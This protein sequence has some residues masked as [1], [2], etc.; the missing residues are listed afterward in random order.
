MSR[1]LDINGQVY[2]RLTV[3]SFFG[4]EAAGGGQKASVWECLCECGNVVRKRGN[5][6]RT[7]NTKSCGCLQRECRDALGRT[8][9]T[10]GKS[11]TKEYQSYNHARDRCNN[12][13]SEY[14]K[15]YGGRGIKFLFTS[16]EIFLAEVGLAPTFSHSIDRFPN[17]NGHYEPDNVRWATKKEQSENRR[18]TRLVDFRGETLTA[19]EVSVRCGLPPKTVGRRLLS[20]WCLSCAVS[21][22][23][24]YHGGK[25]RQCGHKS[26]V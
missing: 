4:R 1:L 26:E 11:G 3:T 18:S 22:P 21:V 9:I 25:K 13:R 15:D 17:K 23:A 8:R 6:L 19:Q 14:Y 16:F 20:G 10:H 7:G 5:D 2:G 12:P 24:K